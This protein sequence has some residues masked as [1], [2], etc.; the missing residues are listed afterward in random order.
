[1][2]NVGLT[3]RLHEHVAQLNALIDE[4]RNKRKPRIDGRVL[5]HAVYSIFHLGLKKNEIFFV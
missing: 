2:G 1:M 3:G 5:S 4:I